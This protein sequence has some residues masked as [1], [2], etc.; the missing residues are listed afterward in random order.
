MD[1]IKGDAAL[2]I[3]PKG[4]I[5][6]GKYTNFYEIYIYKQLRIKAGY[7]KTKETKRKRDKSVRGLHRIR[8]R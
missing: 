1:I 3:V 2:L 6:A 7:R 5:W 8:Q 4:R